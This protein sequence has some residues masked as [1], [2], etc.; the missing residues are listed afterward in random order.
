VENFELEKI[1]FH[2]YLYRKDGKEVIATKIGAKLKTTKAFE[3]SE[4]NLKR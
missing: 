2:I 1:F 3:K 4:A